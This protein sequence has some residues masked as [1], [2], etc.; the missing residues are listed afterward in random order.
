MIVVIDGEP[1][2]QT[3]PSNPSIDWTSQ[4]AASVTPGERGWLIR[5]GMCVQNAGMVASDGLD[6]LE[7][8]IAQLDDRAR[9]DA[10]LERYRVAGGGPRVLD[11]IPDGWM[12][13]DGIARIAES[14]GWWPGEWQ[15]PELT[16]S[17]T[18]PTILALPADPPSDLGVLWVG[19]GTVWERDWFFTPALRDHAA[20]APLCGFSGQAL[21]LSM[22]FPTEAAILEAFLVTYDELGIDESGE[23]DPF[24]VEWVTEPP[25]NA[26]PGAERVHRRLVELS[27]RWSTNHPCWLPDLMPRLGEEDWPPD[28][29]R[30]MLGTAP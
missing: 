1:T 3:E 11:G 13:S 29:V 22:V 9:S 6:D 5:R 2:D 27:R 25:V 14:G 19:V 20:N 8:V 18:V 21:W 26:P 28:A 4:V 17:D 30:A 12:I 23:I 7:R 16:D 24:F 15:F 10:R